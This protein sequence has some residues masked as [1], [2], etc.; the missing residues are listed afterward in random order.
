MS[1][2]GV[3]TLIG[4]E[5]D[6]LICEYCG[7]LVTFQE[8]KQREERYLEEYG[9]SEYQGYMF[10]NY[11]GN[12]L[13][14]VYYHT[15]NITMYMYINHITIYYIIVLMQQ[16]TTKIDLGGSLIILNSTT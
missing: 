10:F 3:V 9:D 1:L 12:R 8:A 16:W 4:V 15:Y 6:D 11:S 7:D 5:K 13:W 2:K 14:Y